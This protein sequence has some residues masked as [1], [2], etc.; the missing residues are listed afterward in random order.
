MK[1][2][3]GHRPFA[4]VLER[5]SQRRDR[6]HAESDLLRSPGISTELEKEIGREEGTSWEREGGPFRPLKIR[7]KPDR[8]GSVRSS[9]SQKPA[10][11]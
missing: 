7:V 1:L 3:L 5:A 11:I 2:L 9:D 6:R 10:A 4:H 8:T